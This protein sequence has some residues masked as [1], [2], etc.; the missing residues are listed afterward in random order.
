M[1]ARRPFPNAT[2]ARMR[3]TQT[4]WPP[5]GQGGDGGQL[6]RPSNLLIVLHNRATRR[7]CLSLTCVSLFSDPSYAFLYSHSESCAYIAPP[8]CPPGA[9]RPVAQPTRGMHNS[10]QVPSRATPPL[11]FRCRPHQPAPSPH[12]S[13]P[14]PPSAQAAPA[15]R[16]PACVHGPR[17][18]PS[19]AASCPP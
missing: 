18:P 9:V 3:E 14:S 19:H 10:S 2:C 6:G 15:P 16:R 11:S 8:C 17:P 12:P 1:A 13:P 7:S 4:R 5:R